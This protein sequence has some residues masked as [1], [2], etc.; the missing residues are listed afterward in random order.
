[1]TAKIINLADRLGVAPLPPPAPE[2]EIE[3]AQRLIAKVIESLREGDLLD[4]ANGLE[5]AARH[6]RRLEARPR[7][8]PVAARSRGGLA[9]AL[10]RWRLLFS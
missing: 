9:F 2:G 5:F 10:M 6:L 1:M 4:T 7:A 3:Y 8:R